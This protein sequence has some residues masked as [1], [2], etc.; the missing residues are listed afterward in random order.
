MKKRGPWAEKY[1]LPLAIRLV[2]V[3]P[4]G[5]ALIFGALMGNL[6]WFFSKRRVDRAERHCVAA[7]GVGITPART[8]VRNSYAGMGRSAVEFARMRQLLPRLRELVS[9]EGKE[10]L[11][12]AL[13]RGR[14]VLGMTAHIGNWELAGA[15][16]A[17]EGYRVTPIY[18]PQ[19]NRG[20]VEDFI[21]RERTETAGMN[22]VSSRGF[23]L[24]KAFRV[25]GEGGILF[26]LQDLDAR[27]E[28]VPVPFLG[29]PASTATGIVKMYQRFGAPVVPMMTLR[30]P[31][32]YRHTIQVQKILSDLS[33]EDGE[34]FGTNMVKSL[35]MCNNILGD[36][37]GK[38]PDQWMWLLDRWKSV[39]EEKLR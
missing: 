33:D 4:H 2:R 26:F 29:L 38:Y 32:G 31:D 7:L 5:T 25:P 18:T 35:R 3:L 28:G 36:W 34:P 24:R 19:R 22:L 23:A 30:H 14:G 39:D 11:D 20:G 6:L 27:G 21:A 9:I 17:A 10:Y 13:A 16:L 12:G 37:V 15:R 1:L 8:I